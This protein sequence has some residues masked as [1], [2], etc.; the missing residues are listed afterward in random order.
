M[1]LSTDEIMQKSSSRKGMINVKR[2]LISSI[3]TLSLLTVLG[4][5]VIA[6]PA[7]E[8]TYSQL[9]VGGKL[10]SAEV[11]LALVSPDTI[12]EGGISLLGLM[13][14]TISLVGDVK[15]LL[16]PLQ[17]LPLIPFAGAGLTVSLAGQAIFFS[18]HLLAGLEFRAGG[19]PFNFF[20]EAGASLTF[21]P[22]GI[23]LALGGQIGLR[24]D[25]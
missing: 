25:L 1:G 16:G 11:F 14:G 2:V 9:G 12:L 15:L 8:V 17:E 23:G 10:P 7:T 18:P 13:G 5:A 3:V 19:M 22:L 20:G 6:Q 4:G 24:L 21:S